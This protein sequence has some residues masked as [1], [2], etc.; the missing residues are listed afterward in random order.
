MV[1][2]RWY[3]GHCDGRS[4]RASSPSFVVKD[5]LRAEEKPFALF[6]CKQASSSRG[7]GLLTTPS[8]ALACPGP[9]PAQ[10]ASPCCGA[11]RWRSRV[12]SGSGQLLLTQASVA[13]VRRRDDHV[14]GGRDWRWRGSRHNR[15]SRARSASRPTPATT[16]TTWSSEDSPRLTAR[17]AL[18]GGPATSSQGPALMLL[19]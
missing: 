4:F 11:R 17:L 1:G 19:G 10:A 14:V 5:S 2:G 7:R 15:I 9:A 3:Y 8:A 16:S 12:L 13:G 18:E 6:F